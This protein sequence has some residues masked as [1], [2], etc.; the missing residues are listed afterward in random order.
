LHDLLLK[1]FLWSC[2]TLAYLLI[3]RRAYL[4]KVP[5]MPFPA[6]CLNVSWE[7]MMLFEHEFLGIGWATVFVWF[8]LDVVILVQYFLYARP[9][10]VTTL[11]DAMFWPASLAMVAV[12]LGT[13]I[14]LNHSFGDPSGLIAAYFQNALMSV[15]FCGML[16]ARD[17]MRGQSIYIAL[18]K[19]S[20][21]S[22]AALYGEPSTAY[23]I[24]C[25]LLIMAFDLAYVFLLCKVARRDG[26]AV[27][28]RL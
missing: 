8:A 16:L 12:G 24:W 17:N 23:L 20:G 28:R 1:L 25:Y 5:G 22:V 6:T 9:A 18:A 7:G 26:I 19:L 4:D 27:F 2:W 15:L 13:P 14:V 10:Q 3:I 11:A 21:T